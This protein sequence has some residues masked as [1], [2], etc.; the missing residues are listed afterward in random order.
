[1]NMWLLWNFRYFCRVMDLFFYIIC[2]AL[3]LCGLAGCF[4]PVVPGPPLA[5]IGYLTLL[6][7]PAAENMSV[8]GITVIGLLTIGSVVLDYFIP[9]LGVKVFGGTKYGKWGSFV[10]TFAGLFW[11]P[12]GLIMG[13]FLG[14]FIG[15]LLRNSNF[16]DA[17][18]SGLGSLVGFLCGTFFKVIVCLI[19]LIFAI[20]SII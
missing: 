3:C 16:N 14:A 8:W 5:F 9:T 6:L 18:R 15:E 19:I 11:L 20:V 13:P 4:L 12:V 7:T 10:G 17:I 2:F 1:M